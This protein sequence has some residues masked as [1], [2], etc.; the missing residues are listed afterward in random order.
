MNV[1]APT[2]QNLSRRDK[3][4]A[5]AALVAPSSGSYDLSRRRA[6]PFSSVGFS[7][8][9]KS[10]DPSSHDKKETTAELV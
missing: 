3:K 10:L 5:M 9:P 4:E 8:R 7:L 1:C 6:S 2:R